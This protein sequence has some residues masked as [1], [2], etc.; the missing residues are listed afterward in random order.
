MLFLFPGFPIDLSH[1]IGLVVGLPYKRNIAW[2]WG[3][4]TWEYVFIMFVIN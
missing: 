2:W 4:V 1:A 3:F